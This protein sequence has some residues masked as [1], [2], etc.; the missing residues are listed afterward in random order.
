MNDS[1]SR[2]L[3]RIRSSLQVNQAHLQSQADRFPAPHPRGPFVATDLPVLEQFE[4]E[5]T[6]L[7][8][9]V[10]ICDGAADALEQ[11]G[12]LLEA[13]GAQRVMAWNPEDLPIPG[14]ESLLEG[15][16]IAC[17]DP[18]VLGAGDRT[19][20]L[21]ALEPIAVGLTGAQAAV[22]ESGSMLVLSDNGRGRLASLLPPMHIA[23]IPADRIVQTLPDAFALLKQ[24]HGDELFSD[25]S[26]LAV[27]SGPSRTADIELSLTLGVHG[28]KEVHVIVV[29]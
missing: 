17:V 2:I 16:G 13:A 10:H 4:A 25:H 28:P 21:D 8:G 29:H 1:R 9:H 27:I 19:A 23:V 7:H 11:L 3:G 20:R 24:E 5:L 26:N 6:A 22:A 12:S 14:V 15:M 18:Q